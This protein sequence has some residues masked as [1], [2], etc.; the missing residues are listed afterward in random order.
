MIAPSKE[1][2]QNIKLQCI[3]NITRRD[4]MGGALCTS[5]YKG[6]VSSHPGRARVNVRDLG[7]GTARS[8]PSNGGQGAEFCGRNFFLVFESGGVE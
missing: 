8:F 1:E 6:W 4:A 2:S 5:Y 7:E 3:R